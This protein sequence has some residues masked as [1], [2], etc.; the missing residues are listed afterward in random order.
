MAHNYERRFERRFEKPKYNESEIGDQVEQ[1][2][3]VFGAVEVRLFSID[4]GG[5]VCRIGRP[6]DQPSRVNDAF[7][8][9][10]DLGFL[11]FR[12]V[13]GHLACSGLLSEDGVDQ[14]QLVELICFI[15][16]KLLG[17]GHQVDYQVEICSKQKTLIESGEESQQ[18]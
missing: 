10:R 13:D 7:Y 17:T 14:N 11:W 4:D 6:D 16:E 3:A 18:I 9:S 8:P 1:K 12:W 2:I 5:F 15:D